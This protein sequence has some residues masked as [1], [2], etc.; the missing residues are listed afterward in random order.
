MQKTFKYILGLCFLVLFSQALKAQY[1][2]NEPTPLQRIFYGGNIG[3]LFGSHTYVSLNPVVGYRITDR[4]SAGIGGDYTWTKSTYNNYEYE[5]SSYGGSVFASFT[6]V[7]HLGDILPSSGDGALL[8]Y[9]EMAYT[10]VKDLYT[11]ITTASTWVRTPLAGVGYQTP[12]GKKSYMLFM[13][14]YNFNESYYSPYSNPVIK[15]SVQF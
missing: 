14:L 5:G 10:N 6:V 12:I 15:V 2:E 9:G 8:V 11:T 3:L 13:V 1:L 4:L 7:K